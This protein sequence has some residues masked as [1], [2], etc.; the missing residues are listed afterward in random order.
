MRF[1]TG[2]VHTVFHNNLCVL[3]NTAV[4]ELFINLVLL[5]ER[6]YRNKK[7]VTFILIPSYSV[8]TTCATVTAFRF[9]E[10]HYRRTY[11]GFALRTLARTQL[12]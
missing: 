11:E 10:R 12:I 9:A 2:C 4:L 8:A 7:K 1:L 6:R 5:H 3:I